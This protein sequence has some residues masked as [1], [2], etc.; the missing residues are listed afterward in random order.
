MVSQKAIFIVTEE[1]LTLLEKFQR[2]KKHAIN[3]NMQDSHDRQ[4][5]TTCRMFM[6]PMDTVSL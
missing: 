6:S 3:S 5:D 4:K 2:T 1:C